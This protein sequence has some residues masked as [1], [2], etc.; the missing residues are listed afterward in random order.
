VRRTIAAVDTA[1]L[2]AERDAATCQLA[3]ELV[4]AVDAGIARGRG[5]AAAMA[6]RELR[7]TLMMLPQPESDA[8]AERW[9]QLVDQLV[10]AGDGATQ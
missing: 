2:L 7:E 5:S 9:Q 10:N 8:D 6:A 4:A 3:L 1:G